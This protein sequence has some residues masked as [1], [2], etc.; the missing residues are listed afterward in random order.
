MF[1]YVR[2][3]GQ[4]SSLPEKL[5][6]LNCLGS[7]IL[8]ISY[9]VSFL[10]IFRRPLSAR[11]CL[12]YFLKCPIALWF[13]HASSAL[14][15]YLLHSL[16]P[17]QFLGQRLTVL[18]SLWLLEL[19]TWGSF[20]G[21]LTQRYILESHLGGLLLVVWLLLPGLSAPSSL[22]DRDISLHF[23]LKHLGVPDVSFLLFHVGVIWGQGIV[24]ACAGSWG[25]NAWSKLWK[26]DN[27]PSPS[28]LMS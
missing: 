12:F 3:L 2:G 23:S 11:Y 4:L 7:E 13:L 24:Q 19:W 17:G 25:L 15:H 6:Q 28:R 18:W 21:P 26:A 20:W 10:S 8:F 22:G 1:Y 9:W 16:L 5:L 27:F 14:Q